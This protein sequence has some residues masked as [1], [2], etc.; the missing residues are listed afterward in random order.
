MTPSDTGWRM[1]S[2]TWPPTASARVTLTKPPG[3][4]ESALRM[5]ANQA[6]TEAA[7]TEHLGRT[8][9]VSPDHSNHDL[10]CSRPTICIEDCKSLPVSRE[11]FTD[12]QSALAVDV[13]AVA[14][15]S[16]PLVAAA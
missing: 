14:L 8:A 12:G 11:G 13:R 1:N 6:H 2:D 3:N 15:G 10:T 7:R 9:P 16:H 5:H 4:T